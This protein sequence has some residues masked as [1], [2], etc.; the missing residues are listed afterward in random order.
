MAEKEY[1]MGRTGVFGGGKET[2]VKGSDKIKP[3][4]GKTNLPPNFM[5]YVSK[6][7]SVLQI[8]KTAPKISVPSILIGLGVGY[9]GSKIKTWA[10]N[11]TGKTGNIPKNIWTKI[12]E[13]N[14]TFG[15]EKSWI[16]KRKKMQRHSQSPTNSKAHGGSVKKYARGGGVRGAKTY[17]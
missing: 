12:K 13:D 9:L 17:G 7:G 6:V 14:K 5:K 3:Y 2:T 15:E 8:A 10:D 1:K 11:R 4:K 16:A